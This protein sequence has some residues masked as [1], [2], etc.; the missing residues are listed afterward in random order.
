VCVWLKIFENKK[1]E[2]WLMFDRTG[3]ADKWNKLNSKELHN[4]YCIPETVRV[5][6]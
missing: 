4:F 6:K 5:I 2:R 1:I 3:I